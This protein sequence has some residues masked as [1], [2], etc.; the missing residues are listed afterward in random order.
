MTKLDAFFHAVLPESKHYIFAYSTTFTNGVTGKQVKALTNIP[1]LSEKKDSVI[2]SLFR[3]NQPREREIY[4]AT[5][6]YDIPDYELT[7]D[8][9]NTQYA[10]DVERRKALRE[11]TNSVRKAEYITARKC[12]YIDIDGAKETSTN[13]QGRKTFC[14]VT[15]MLEAVGQVVK[16]FDLP[17]P[18][19]VVESG[20]GLHVYWAFTESISLEE[21]RYMQMQINLVFFDLAKMEVDLSVAKNANGIIRIPTSFNNKRQVQGKL[22]GKGRLHNPTDLAVLLN[23][24]YERSDIVFSN[25]RHDP[26]AHLGTPPPSLV[27]PAHIAEAIKAEFSFAHYTKPKWEHILHPE[28]GCKMARW[29]T[30]LGRNDLGNDDWLALL[31]WTVNCENGESLI[32]TVSEGHP[33]YTEKET[34]ERASSLDSVYSCQR[35]AQIIK[36][37]VLNPACVGCIHLGKDNVPRIK[38]PLEISR[39]IL[40]SEEIKASEVDDTPKA[41]LVINTSVEQPISTPVPTLRVENDAPLEL[42]SNILIDTVVKEYMPDSYMILDP[43]EL[44]QYHTDTLPAG[45]GYKIPDPEIEGVFIVVRVTVGFVYVV[46]VIR[47]SNASTLQYDFVV[48]QADY[49]LANLRLSAVELASD[50][51]VIKRFADVGVDFHLQSTKHKRARLPL[52]LDYI[53][54]SVAKRN[55]MA[56]YTSNMKQYGW[57]AEKNGF[58]LGNWLIYGGNRVERAHPSKACASYQHA[59]TPLA[60]ARV[61]KW[62]DASN[63]YAHEGMESAQFIM[64][65]SLASPVLG[66]LGTADAQGAL[67]NIFSTA[68]GLGKTTLA[69]SALSIW[70]RASAVGNQ[71]GLAGISSDTLKSR[72]FNMS[73]LQNIPFY[74]DETTD[75]TTKACYQLVY[76]ITQG[77]DARRMKQSGVEAHEILGGWNMVAFT[78]SNKSLVEKLYSEAGASGDAVHAR[79]LE[80]DMAKLKSAREHYDYNTIQSAFRTMQTENYGIVGQDYLVNMADKQDEL[81]REFKAVREELHKIFNFLPHERFWANTAVVGVMG[82]RQG[83]R[84]GYF[85]YDDRAVIEWL[86]ELLSYTRR[87]RTEAQVAIDQMVEEFINDT[88]A[89]SVLGVTSRT[90]KWVAGRASSIPSYRNNISEAEYRLHKHNFCMFVHNRYGWSPKE[91]ITAM[92]RLFGA[93]KRTRFLSGL[94]GK[95][96][97]DLPVIQIEAWVVPYE[98]LTSNVENDDD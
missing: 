84:L 39:R 11:Y 88:S 3:T 83:N 20:G 61:Q 30:T 52:F 93:P 81:R 41:L 9:I 65:V 64:G 59:M 2:N 42:N 19:Y 79:V 29:A 53:R 43:S 32:H 70:G 13:E 36:G 12:I 68:S 38:N 17:R 28:H 73:L 58:L 55:S 71:A 76:Q 22:H 14:D 82:I 47:D 72:M 74:M 57:T 75:L 15:A 44:K 7:V 49:K 51:D 69:H 23:S 10:D 50:E 54:Q 91:V 77:Q 21:W 26:F 1:V 33:L 6:G 40:M 35:T 92:N 66:L 60:T 56:R 46:D 8:R 97:G 94:T 31:S 87:E 89:D 37:K 25:A 80:I 98:K 4:F 90:A 62:R 85:N 78:S 86:K 24:A 96:L 48:Q 16:S 5:A 27:F 95:E 34:N 67:I 18:S 63:I 45:I